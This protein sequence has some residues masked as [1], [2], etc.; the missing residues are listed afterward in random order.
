MVWVVLPLDE[1]LFLP[2]LFP[3]VRYFFN[4]IFFLSVCVSS[5]RGFFRVSI[6]AIRDIRFEQ[7]Y[8]E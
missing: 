8:V 3:I 5:R 4:F 6:E 2:S 1:V 7:A